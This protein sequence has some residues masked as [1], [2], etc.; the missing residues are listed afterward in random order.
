M[1]SNPVPV[2]VPERQPEV[3][4]NPKPV[5]PRDEKKATKFVINIAGAIHA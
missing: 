2:R 4:A 3:P 1:S 5:W